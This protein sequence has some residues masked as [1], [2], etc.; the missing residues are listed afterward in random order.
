MPNGKLS[1][2]GAEL[3][4]VEDDPVILME[5]EAILQDAGAQIACACQ[6]VS[7]AA[8]FLA[9]NR[10]TAAVLD[11]QIGNESVSSVVCELSAR[12]VPFLFYTGQPEKDVA[13]REWPRGTVLSKP[14]SAKEILAALTALIQSS[15]NRSTRLS[16][17]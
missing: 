17:E 7:E 1:L 11:I 14:S 15:E 2:N 8:T 5:L 9:K 4:L 6:C 13:A 3:L 10:P 16:T 12:G